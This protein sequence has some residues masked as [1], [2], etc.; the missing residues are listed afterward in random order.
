MSNRPPGKREHLAESPRPS[1]NL[2]A[3]NI[4]RSLPQDDWDRSLAVAFDSRAIS[5]LS[6]QKILACRAPSPTWYDGNSTIHLGPVHSPQHA[7][8]RRRRG[9]RVRARP[10]CQRRLAPG[11]RR[12]L[13]A[14]LRPRRRSVCTAPSVPSP[15]LSSSVAQDCFDT[16]ISLPSSSTTLLISSS[17]TP[18]G[19]TS[20]SFV[21]RHTSRSF[22]HRQRMGRGNPP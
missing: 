8:D 18:P 21:H 14:S 9:D 5:F 3:C 17:I 2:A 15:P 20:R 19:D 1:P 10:L 11:G 16:S 13:V 12:P 4:Q 22:V 6:I 7:F